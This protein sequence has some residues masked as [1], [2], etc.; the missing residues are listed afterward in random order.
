MAKGVFLHR[1]DS[2]YDD[3]PESRYQFPRRYLK[4]ARACIGD[5]IIYLEPVKAGKKGYY[6]VAQVADIVPDPVLPDMFIAQIAPNT[7]LPF[8]RPVP[9]NDAGTYPERSVLNDAGRISGRAQAGMRN[10]PDTDFDHILALG[11]PDDLTILPRTGDDTDATGSM[12]REQQQP[13]MF[14]QARD[15]ASF[16]TS[17]PVR[18][19]IFR[20]RV[21]AAYDNRCAFTGSRYI[22]GGGRA[23]AEAAHIRPVAAAGPDSVRNG[24]ALCGTAHWMFDRGLLSL[25]DD[26]TIL[27]SRAVNDRDGLDR[28]LLPSRI[29]LP[30]IDA[31]DAPHPRFLAWHREHVFKG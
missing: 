20:S 13:F 3:E 31:A 19:R 30:T 24:I 6:A 22:N 11:I 4:V 16:L 18:D 12:L 23:E 26:R 7:Y 10:I 15:R 29:A 25:A 17:R 28:L 1:A 5:W 27:V 2:I 8:D 14:D 9:F 21:L